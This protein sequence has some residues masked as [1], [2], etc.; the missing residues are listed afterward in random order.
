MRSQL[1]SLVCITLF[2]TGC[3]S[4][5]PSSTIFTVEVDPELSE[6]AKL[7]RLLLLVSSNNDSEPR[8]QINDG[9]N[10]QIVF[11]KDIENWEQGSK[12]IFDGSEFGYP[13]KNLN[14]LKPG[15]YRVQAFLHKYEIYNLSSG[16]T[17]NLPASWAAGQQW[18]REPGNIYSTPKEI[19][20][21]ASGGEFELQ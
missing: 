7:G 8:F 21:S 10:T 6:Q 4:N 13:I 3:I 15:K 5:N 20:I 2:A 9:P 11:G 16:Q 14:D 19:E 18:N 1:F 17:V 12:V